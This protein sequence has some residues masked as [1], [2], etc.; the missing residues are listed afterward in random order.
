MEPKIRG[1]NL[2]LQWRRAVF[3]KERDSHTQRGCVYTPTSLLTLRQTFLI[4]LINIH[5]HGHIWSFWGK[6]NFYDKINGSQWW[7]CLGQYREYINENQKRRESV[8]KCLENENY[9]VPCLMALLRENG[10]REPTPKVPPDTHLSQA[11]SALISPWPL[12]SLYWRPWW[13]SAMALGH[14]WAV[15]CLRTTCMSAGRT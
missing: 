11:S 6:L 15:T 2:L 5:L 10:I 7:C 1:R 14:L 8:E 9:C 3:M 12:C 13:C 4:W